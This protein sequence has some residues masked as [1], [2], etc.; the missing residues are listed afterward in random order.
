MSIQA[1]AGNSL[2]FADI[3]RAMRSM[4]DELMVHDEARRQ[5]NPRRRSFWIEEDGEWS[6]LLASEDDLQD[7]LSCSEVR[8]ASTSP[9]CV[10]PS[11]S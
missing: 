7:V 5:Q 11:G 6:L 1:A 10:L 4:E 9:K 8:W 3:E 2:L